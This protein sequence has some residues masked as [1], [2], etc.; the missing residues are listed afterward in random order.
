MPLVFCSSRM[1]RG[2]SFAA[3]AASGEE[4]PTVTRE[5]ALVGWWKID[6]ESGTTLAD[7]SSTGNDAT[8]PQAGS[9][10]SGKNGNCV[11]LDGTDDYINIPSNSVNFK[12][13]F[14]MTWWAYADSHNRYG[15]PF[16]QANYHTNAGSF[17]L[18]WYGY[19]D[20]ATGGTNKTLRYAIE[21]T[22]SGNSINI[23]YWDLDSEYVGAWHHFAFT[24]NAD[25]ESELYYDGSVQSID[26]ET[27][28]GS[29]AGTVYTSGQDVEEGQA[30]EI[31]RYTA[32]HEFPG[33]IDD[34][35]FYNEVLSASDIN[36][37]ANKNGSGEGD[38]P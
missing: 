10:V 37:I 3:S 14:T 25:Q 38:W 7:S 18:Q 1:N 23:C 28:G 32:S 2:G 30:I 27:G 36:L 19:G 6:E 22:S 17:S 33:K 16:T 34:I 31:G 11:H 21:T 29:Y 35:R 15:G 5:D 12:P 13:P 26:S 9:L 24:L 8:L 20:G 4:A